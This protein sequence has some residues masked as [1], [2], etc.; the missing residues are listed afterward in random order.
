MKKVYRINL[1]VLLIAVTGFM[2]SFTAFN[3]NDDDPLP[4]GDFLDK[5]HRNTAAELLKKR[6][7]TVTF[8][9]VSLFNL[10]S[11]SNSQILNSAVTK[12][13]FFELDRIALKN[14]NQS[15]PENAI[16]KFPQSG[17]KELELELA[18]V[19]FLPSDF[20]IK[21]SSGKSIDYKGGLYYQGIIKGNEN[22]MAAV[23]VFEN[24]VIGIIST[25]EGNY[26]LGSI[27]DDRGNNTNQYIL[28]NEIDLKK[29]NSFLCGVDSRS[30]ELNRGN[31]MPKV[32]V[33]DNTSTTQPVRMYYVCD[34]QMYL[35][36][37][38][39]S[40]NVI[41]YVTA[42][43]NQVK[44]LYQNETIPMV[45]APSVF[46]YDSADPYRAYG[47]EETLE[48]LKAFGTATKSDFVGDLAQLI[49]TRTPVT[50]AIAWIN[51]LCQS[52]EPS[53]QSGPYAFSEIENTYQN[54]PIYSWTVE[55]MAHE[56]GHNFASQHTH[57]CVWPTSS[58]QIDSCVNIQGE[59]CVGTDRPNPNGTIMSYC[60][61]PQGGGINFL[62]GF[63]NLPG[64]TIRLGYANALCID[65]SL[66][67]SEVPITYS[68]LQNYPN[69][70]NPSTKIKFALPEAGLVTLRIY[71][72]TGREVTALVDN[73]FY[74]VG[75][76]SLS[77]DA[78]N[79]GLA[80][81]VYLY[82]LEVRRENNPVY[83]E[84]RKM[85]LVK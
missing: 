35:D 1:I 74:A 11:S 83:S 18:R 49:S 77:F 3:L 51:V 31:M 73:K 70:F 6:R 26:N 66:N 4:Q 75:I 68:L 12:A 47:T 50:G 34:Y 84:I 52:Y 85:V 15:R 23:S 25:K 5:G 69:P 65:S 14:I 13:E 54:V 81:G 30:I 36:K 41:N 64:D 48:I 44:L 19:Y 22:T 79:H 56:T 42:V 2:F 39:N 80:S 16:L 71:D 63:G 38:S 78:A 37:G 24:E 45:M 67:S 53:S 7:T 60:H 43:F 82:R 21:T 32:N 57:S 46:V 61:I 27:T 62:L 40:T 28:Y 29:E 58:G 8:E 55:V 76:F 10:S 33:S 17:G 72:I 9:T 59:S 20:K